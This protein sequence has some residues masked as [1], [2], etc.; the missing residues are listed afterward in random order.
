MSDIPIACMVLFI[1]TQFPP[2]FLLL[3]R[4]A[5]GIFLLIL[6]LGA[7]RTFRHNQESPAVSPEA[8]HRTLVKGALVNVLN[9]NAYLGWS[10]VMGPLLIEAWG[11]SLGHAVALIGSFYGVMIFVTMVIVLLFAGA[12][13]RGPRVTRILVGLS[14]LA[15]AGF[16]C[17]QLWSCAAGFGLVPG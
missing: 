11:Q 16:G 15:L 7:F 4:L 12:R 10:L 9:P 5:G 1:L 13:S 14:A 17:Y 6:A 3:L 2:L 8:V